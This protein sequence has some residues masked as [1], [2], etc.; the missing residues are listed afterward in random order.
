MS[1]TNLPR[2]NLKLLKVLIVDDSHFMRRL[3]QSIV[4]ALGIRD[5]QTVGTVASAYEELL[6]FPADVIITDL[7]MEP[8]SGFDLIREIRMGSK[9]SNPFVPIIMLSGH[10]ESHRIAYARDIGATEFLAKPISAKSLYSRII[11]VIENERQFV[12]SEDF[13]GP[14]RRRRATGVPKGIEERRRDEI[15]ELGIAKA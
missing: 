3:L 8:Q 11:S 4:D 1:S 10:T 15:R 6:R 5:Y 7:H 14:D 12:R 13:F 9:G 2:Y